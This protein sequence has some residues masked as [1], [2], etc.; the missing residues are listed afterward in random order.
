M[1]KAANTLFF[2]FSVTCL[3]QLLL[4]SDVG[5]VATLLLAAVSSAGM[6]PGVTL[7]ANHLVGVILL[8]QQ[9]QSGLNNTTTKTQHKMEGRL[10]N[11]NEN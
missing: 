5:G 2:V 3:L 6:K 9:P 7:A 1:N 8:G 10:C 11:R 4:G